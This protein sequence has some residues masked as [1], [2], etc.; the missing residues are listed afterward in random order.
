A[1]LVRKSLLIQSAFDEIDNYTDHG[2]L[3]AIAKI[4]LI[5]Y[6]E[7]KIKVQNG[8]IIDEII[9]NEVLND[10]S[11]MTRTIANDD[12]KGINEFKQKLLNMTSNRMFHLP[13][14][15]RKL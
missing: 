12:F 4:I 11:R 6:Q 8:S 1:N 7:G 9:F 3:L 5:L 2:K 13:Y 10:I 15:K 14:V